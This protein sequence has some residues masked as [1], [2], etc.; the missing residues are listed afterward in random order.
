MEIFAVEQP[1]ARCIGIFVIS[2]RKLST[3]SAIFIAF[4][5]WLDDGDI[6]HVTQ[7]LEMTNQVHLVSE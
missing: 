1:V 2:F 3:W 6:N 7:T 4:W 5:Q